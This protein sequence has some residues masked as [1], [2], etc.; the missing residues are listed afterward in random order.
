[1]SEAK[2]LKFTADELEM[3]G[4]PLKGITIFDYAKPSEAAPKVRFYGE[5]NKLIGEFGKHQGVFIPRN[6][7]YWFESVG[8]EPLEILQAESIDRR[9]ANRRTDYEAKK[10]PG[11]PS[12][13]V[14]GMS[15]PAP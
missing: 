1:M 6:T 15:R 13:V 8:E 2:E 10:R 4:E 11:V 7:P 5:G 3:P 14:R 12:K 9:G